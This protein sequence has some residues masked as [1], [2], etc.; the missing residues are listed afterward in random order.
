MSQI[1][2]SP[3]PPQ[4][5]GYPPPGGPVGY[6]GPQAMQ[7]QGS[8]AWGIVSLI[9]GF[10]GFCIP[11]V[12]G[13]LAALFGLVGIAK[14][15]RVKAGVGLS[16]FGLI[17]GLLSLGMWLLFSGSIFALI[18]GTKV[19]RDLAGQ[20]IKDL[21]AG[22][23]TAAQAETDGSIS[24]QKMQ[25]LST[26]LKGYGTV[27][28]VTTLATNVQNSNADLGGIV[29]FGAVKK[30]FAMKQTKSGDKWK[31][32]DF[33]LVN[34]GGT[35]SGTGGG[36]TTGSSSSGTSGGSGAGSGSGTD[37]GTGSDGK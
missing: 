16:V 28:D 11:F 18:M 23:I 34:E 12:G 25:D 32:V 27:T 35:S 10:L 26:E 6:A 31:V 15:R 22:N 2:P 13:G 24:Q 37:S 3:Y 33:T 20:F 30:G 21:A 36:P 8:N 5:P 17:L 7:P 14:G 1:P 9:T 19:N 4:G 29:S